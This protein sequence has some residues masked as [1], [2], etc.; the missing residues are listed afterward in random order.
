MNRAS[1]RAAGSVFMVVVCVAWLAPVLFALYV[2]FRPYAETS[3]YGYV[4][5]PHQLTFQNYVNAWTQSDMLR[6]RM[7]A[8]TGKAVLLA[9]LT[10]LYAWS[11][12]ALRTA[13]RSA[14]RSSSVSGAG[15]AG[16]AA[17]SV[18]PL[19]PPWPPVRRRALPARAG[20]G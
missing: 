13:M 10:S 11:A 18:W 3:Q 19:M 17:S 16:A 9:V 12:R 6:L 2:S 14:S 7:P 15:P 20:A 8:N 4:S 1:W 5:L